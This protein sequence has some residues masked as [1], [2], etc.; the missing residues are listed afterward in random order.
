MQAI[1]AN[2]DESDPVHSPDPIAF[3][4]VFARVLWGL[5]PE[6]V[7]ER[8]KDEIYEVMDELAGIVVELDGSSWSRSH[9]ECVG[10]SYLFIQGLDL[11]HGHLDSR[12][13]ALGR[14]LSHSDTF[15]YIYA[16]DFELRPPFNSC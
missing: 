10:W 6:D 16:I 14:T 11:E 4:Y 8:R 5:V 1:R 3:I 13:R 7:V 2:A 9:S 12:L 15:K